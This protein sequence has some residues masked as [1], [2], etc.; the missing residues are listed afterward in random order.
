MKTLH[1][2][3]G[4]HKIG[5]TSI[6]NTFDMNRKTLNEMGFHY[7]GDH[8]NHHF[9]FFAT[10]ASSQNLPR[11]FKSIPEDKLNRMVDKYFSK[12]E[13]GSIQILTNK[14]FLLN[15]SLCTMKST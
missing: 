4:S 2:H 11:Q 10:K 3:I 5:T 12:L 9:S 8:Q 6:Q 15:T 14:L 1:L 13:K 7:P